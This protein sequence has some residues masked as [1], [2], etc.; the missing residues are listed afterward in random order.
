MKQ[1]MNLPLDELDYRMMEEACQ[2]KRHVTLDFSND[3]HYHYFVN[4]FGGASR[5][6]KKAPELFSILQRQR[7][8]DF[9]APQEV[10]EPGTLS[11]QDSI[12]I[13]YTNVTFQTP[14]A[15]KDVTPFYH[16]SA[17]PT[18]A[19][20][21][22]QRNCMNIHS[23]IIDWNNKRILNDEDSYVMPDEHMNYTAP[24]S[25]DVSTDECNRT[26]A[27]KITSLFSTMTDTADGLYLQADYIQSTAFTHSSSDDIEQITLFD[28]VI[29]YGAERKD[30]QQHETDP[31]LDHHPDEI[32][33][34]YNR[35]WYL[36]HPDY[37]YNVNLD[38]EVPE[39]PVKFPFRIKIKLGNDAYFCTDQRG[40]YLALDSDPT[41]S[42]SRFDNEKKQPI[43]YGSAP[44]ILDWS[45]LN[46]NNGI[47]VEENDKHQ[48]ISLEFTF[49]ED[50]NSNLCAEKDALL[51]RCTYADFYAMLCLNTCNK[52]DDNKTYHKQTTSVFVQWQQNSGKQHNPTLSGTNQMHVEHLFYRW[53]CLGKNTMIRTKNGAI[54]AQNIAVGDLL[55]NRAGKEVRVS[56]IVTGKDKSILHI[57]FTGG[58]IRMSKTHTVW[59]SVKGPMPAIDLQ[60]DDTIL[61]WNE[62][63]QEIPVTIE[64][65]E[66]EKYEDTVYN[67]EFE[68]ET[69]LVGNGLIV[70]DST[71]QQN[72]RPELPG[73]EPPVRSE[74]VN[75]LIREMN[76]L[77]T[78][79]E[80]SIPPNHVFTKETECLPL[81]YFT[82][83]ALAASD[84]L[85][86]EKEAQSIAEYCQYLA[87]NATTGGVFVDKVPNQL[88]ATKLC[89]NYTKDGTK[90]F[91]VPIIPTA[92]K[93]WYD[94]SELDNK[95][96]WFPT[97]DKDQT[98]P[99]YDMITDVLRPFHYPPVNYGKEPTE[100][101][102]N[103]KYVEILLD[104]VSEKAE[105]PI[106]RDTLMA[107]GTVIHLLADCTLH[108]RFSPE[109]NWKNL[110]RT[111]IILDPKGK[112]VSD[113]YPPFTN[114]DYGTY[115]KTTK[116]PAGL[117]QIGKC[118]ERSYL[119][120]DYNYPLIT[121]ELPLDGESSQYSGHR[122]PVN[123]SRFASA[124]KRILQF[125]CKCKNTHFD[126]TRWTLLWNK[127]MENMYYEQATD[128]SDLENV[129]QKEFPQ[130]KFY[131][132]PVTIYNRMVNGNPDQEDTLDKYSEFFQYTLMLYRLKKGE[133]PLG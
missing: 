33:V 111:N 31:T 129:W 67:F 120:F 72:Y 60:P 90:G 37:E 56:D 131:Y 133:K 59:H 83:K 119:R 104:S 98:E 80:I 14:Q 22:G 49:P 109:R 40:S 61:A 87:D 38:H 76:N 18:A 100:T 29:K 3:L 11:L 8:A 47:K 52:D 130:I 15:E 58:S 13:T 32:V 103:S 16:I 96:S 6:Q 9:T 126:E 71:A 92:M 127:I 5:L 25:T 66:E 102:I 30:D 73:L 101:E 45:S 82:V 84:D 65:I 99:A 48:V 55:L 124:A 93:E 79:S 86:T 20:A 97:T 63:E 17:L 115:D 27:Y 39:M 85:Y 77:T 107:M 106:S 34:A 91:L 74:A 81:H 43:A 89:T 108:E 112:N 19:Y 75:R 78:D 132:N 50:W 117:Q 10:R 125:L 69:F 24:I 62:D 12:E 23:R 4:C 53:G 21:S 54:K 116:Y 2:N 113:L 114:F 88:K 44:L 128:F 64:G 46:E 26:H 41:I 1:A 110:G 123:P 118:M 68:E 94:S 121:Q 36:H 51:D 105:Q 42:L 7:S 122:T 35:S 28:P 95:K 57:R 70:G